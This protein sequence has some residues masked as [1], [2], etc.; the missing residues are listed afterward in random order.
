LNFYCFGRTHYDTDLSLEDQIQKICKLF[1]NGAEFVAEIFR[2]YEA[3]NN[4]ELPLNQATDQLRQN[5]DANKVY[6]LFDQALDATMNDAAAAN[7]IRLLR[8]AFRYTMLDRD[9]VNVGDPECEELIYMCRN[10][11]SYLTKGG[12]G[13]ALPVNFYLNEKSLYSFRDPGGPVA[14]LSKT[15]KWYAFT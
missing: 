11:N 14:D 6:A 10:F 9:E 13:I 4:G 8:M 12:Y 15:D 3:T 1:G 5:I 2:I 7:N